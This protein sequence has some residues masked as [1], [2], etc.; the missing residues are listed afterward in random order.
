MKKLFLLT[1]MGLALLTV[2]SCSEKKE[3][4]QTKGVVTTLKTFKDSLVTANVV[5]N[6]DTLLFKL[7]D[8][9][10]VNG[11]F[12]KDD[13]VQI[14]YIEGR[15]DTL[16]ALIITVLSKPVQYIDLNDTPSDTLATRSVEHVDSLQ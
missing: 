16:R 2:V 9:R 3:L 11:M 8:A 1:V 13:S 7:A 15:G 5:V 10:L 12:I 6:G 14:D 4:K